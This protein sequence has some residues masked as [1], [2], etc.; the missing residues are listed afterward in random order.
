MFPFLVALLLYDLI[1]WYF[2][3]TVG[4]FRSH[5][6]AMPWRDVGIE[7]LRVFV[8][9]A[10]NFILQVQQKQNDAALLLHALND[11]VFLLCSYFLGLRL[12]LANINANALESAYNVPM[13]VC[14]LGH[15]GLI[16]IVNKPFQRTHKHT[17]IEKLRHISSEREIFSFPFRVNRNKMRI[18]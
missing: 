8:L 16:C 13:C 10:T 5:I 6:F 1:I 2:T 14:V 18:H 15:I 17:H 4:M 11:C 9:I 3:E 12:D 7:I